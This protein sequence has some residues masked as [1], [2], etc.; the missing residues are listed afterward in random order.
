MA[1]A[2]DL[3]A[4]ESDLR[5]R[6]AELDAEIGE[7]TK[8][9]EDAGS[10]SFGKRVGEGTSQAIDRFAAVGVAQELQP[11]RERIERALAKLDEGSYGTCDRCG[12]AIAPGRLKA[13]PE[14]ALC[15]DCARAAR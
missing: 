9:P 14:S 1:D 4:I 3:E 6:L 8:P 13:A 2:L 10:I 11:I 12:A 7:L 5:G 15:I